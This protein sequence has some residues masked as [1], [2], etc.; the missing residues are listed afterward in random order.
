[1]SFAR[2]VR[3]SGVV[4]ALGLLTALSAT[5]CDDRS[6]GPNNLT[7]TTPP[8]QFAQSITLPGLQE[9]LA[10][11][12][13]RVEIQV[14]ADSLVA[15]RVRLDDADDLN[16]P[17]E[18]DSRITAIATGT[19]GIDT[20]TLALGGIQVEF[21]ASAHVH[22]VADNDN[23]DDDMGGA[24][25][26][27]TEVQSALAAGRHPGVRAS[28]AAPATP[29]GPTDGAFL[30]TDLDLDEDAALPFISMNV[31]SA[32][33]LF[34]QTPPPDGWIEVLGVKI[35][36]EVSTGVTK[37]E[38]EEHGLQGSQ[39]FEG[40]VKSVDTTG[41]TATLD[42]GTVLKVVLGTEFRN[43]PN[44]NTVLTSLPAVQQALAAGDTVRAEGRGLAISSNPDTLDVIEVTFVV[45]TAV[46]HE[47]PP[48]ILAFN[49]TLASVD[50]T[51]SEITL[52]NG[53]VVRVVAGTVLIGQTGVSTLKLAADS[54]A[55]HVTVRAMGRGL[56]DTV[57]PPQVLDGI[58][59]FLSTGMVVLPLMPGH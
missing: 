3:A 9:G 21:D 53:T 41:G 54:L 11:S 38:E 4:A 49:D 17:E 56:L 20:L 58:F 47:P 24:S 31:D 18:I 57:G 30:A 33:V 48:G 44:D 37:L 55:A 10:T 2:G 15:N 32:N 36:L 14:L 23:D 51:N 22:A 19:N 7:G 29:Q 8:L 28:R 59:V 35:A 26:F 34:N 50:T 5:A 13:T 1:M 16:Q 6:T 52:G 12:A 25:A 45:R 42:N 39:E 40:A 46:E 43:A 27:V